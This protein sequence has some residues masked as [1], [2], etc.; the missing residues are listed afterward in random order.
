MRTRPSSIPS[1]LALLLLGVLLAA[2]RVPIT[3]AVLWL[4]AFLLMAF[5]AALG[6]SQERPRMLEYC[7]QAT[8]TLRQAA[9]GRAQ[10]IK[11]GSNLGFNLGDGKEPDPGRGKLER[12]RHP[13]HHL[14]DVH[15]R[16]QVSLRNLKSH[17]CPV[18]A[19]QEKPHSAE[20]I[21][22]LHLVILRKAHPRHF[23]HPFL[24]QI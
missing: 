6:F 4:P 20:L 24:R 10:E 16:G 11:A 3:W 15:N 1:R 19:F 18:S 23:Q 17:A 21:V 5:L 7:A 22:R 9:A 2:Y 14:A 13:F 12:Q 8:V